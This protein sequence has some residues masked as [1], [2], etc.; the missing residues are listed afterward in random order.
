MIR[1]KFKEVEMRKVE[2]ELK[3][4]SKIEMAEMAKE[5]RMLKIRRVELRLKYDGE[6]KPTG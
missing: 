2:D 3:I 4:K 6:R 1:Q 5:D